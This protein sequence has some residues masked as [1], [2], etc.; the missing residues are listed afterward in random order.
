MSQSFTQHNPRGESDQTYEFTEKQN[1]VMLDLAN[2]IE[3]VAAPL[4]VVGGLYSIAAILHIIM[5]FKAPY[6]WFAV[7]SIGL[8]A[9]LLLCLGR[10]TKQAGES[11]K[12][13]ATTSGQ[14]INHLM[15]ALDNMRKKY[16]VLSSFVKVYVFLLLIL[17]VGLVAS[18]VW[19]W[20][21]SA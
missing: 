9:I 2:A 3:W 19:T 7:F 20:K 5:A 10:W 4:L 21:Q 6:H 1:Q 17:L 13:V 11:F 16:V 12:R 8:L 14:D 15:E 18:L